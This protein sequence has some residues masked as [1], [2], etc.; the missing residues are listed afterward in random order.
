MSLLRPEVT[1]MLQRWR[2]VLAG[3]AVVLA[4]LWLAR[5]G[6]PFFLA[7][8]GLVMLAGAALALIGYRRQRFQS[9]GMAP[10]VVQMVE[11]QVAYFGPETGGFVALRELVE[12]RLEGAGKTW[13]LAQ[14]DG[15]ELRIPVGAKGSEVL[16]D[17]FAALPGLGMHR[18]LAAMEGAENRRMDAQV[19]WRRCALPALT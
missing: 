9:G 13:V 2:E 4:G 5:L 15:A 1:A 6:G 16:F 8:G 14:S 17:A 19:I 11:G 10:G 18:L 7:V 12:L 3:L